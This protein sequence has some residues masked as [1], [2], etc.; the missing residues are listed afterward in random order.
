M[1][2]ILLKLAGTSFF[3]CF[4]ANLFAQTTGTLT[5]TFMPV[6]KTPTYNG[7]SQHVL[8]AW[9]QNTTG[10]GTASFVK[11]K[12]RYVGGGT[13]DHLPAW[14]A[15]A[16]CTSG[17]ATSTGC[18][19]ID[20]TTGATLSSFSA[21][22]LTWDGKKGAAAT[23]TLQPDGIYKVTIQETWDHGTT[24]TAIT[25]YTFTKGANPDHR[26]ITGDV[27]FG[28]ILIDWVPTSSVTTTGINETVPENPEII[29]Y[30]NPT[31]GV[32]NIDF[33]K[34]TQFKVINILGAVLYDERL[35]QAMDGTKSIDFTGFANGIYMVIVSNQKGCSNHKFILNK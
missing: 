30:P 2:K 34:A 18:N 27:N 8:A 25:S 10:S 22:T 19:T 29:V 31:G 21:K 15:N 13:N 23:G 26:V 35:E 11:T 17:I 5:F 12:L 20:G 9:I 6:A 1:K 4:S 33:K 3:I 24:G 28:D 16:S 7:N 14:A 32:I